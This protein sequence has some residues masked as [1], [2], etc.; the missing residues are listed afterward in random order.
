MSERRFSQV[1][2]R[3]STIV[4]L[5][6]LV[7]AA[8]SGAAK[9][10][11][12]RLG[13]EPLQRDTTN[14]LLRMDAALAPECQQRTLVKA[15]VSRPPAPTSS[16]EEAEPAGPWQE[17]WYVDR[18]GSVVAWD[19]RYTPSELGSTNLGIGLAGEDESAPV[20]R[21]EVHAKPLET[22]Q[23]P[24]S[25]FLVTNTSDSG[26]GS[27]AQAIL[28]ANASPN[29]GGPDLIDFKIPNP[30]LRTISL[31]A[32]LPPL[33][34]PVVIDGY[35]QP[36]AVPNSL[37]D[38]SNAVL[39][40][41]LD[42]SRL[43][44]PAHGL[45]LSAG[46]STV[47]GLRIQGFEG[48]AIRIEGGGSNT[49][50]GTL[51]GGSP[52]EAR[53][54]SNT[55]S[56]VVIVDSSDN[57]VGGLVPSARNV[58]EGNGGP[59]V[60][61]SGVGSIGNAILSNGIVRNA[62]EG[63]DLESDAPGG[64]AERGPGPNNLQP[65]PVLKSVSF[66]PGDPGSKAEVVVEGLLEGDSAATYRVELFATT[67]RPA[68]PTTGPAGNQRDVRSLPEGE[69]FL[70]SLEVIAGEDGK[71]GFQFHLP[72]GVHSRDT[73][74]ATATDR[75][76][77]TSEF[78]QPAGAPVFT[79]R[80]NAGT[81]NW[82]TAANWDPAVVP[83]STDDVLIAENSV[84][85]MTF[86]VTISA[87]ATANSLTLGG[88]VPTQ[89]LSVSSTLTL[90]SASTV[91]VNGVLTQTGGTITGT[92]DLTID[93]TYNWSG[94]TMSGPGTGA[95]AATTVSGPLNLNGNVA[96]ANLRILNTGGLTTWSTGGIDVSRGAIIDNTSTWDVRT[97]TTITNSLG[98][99]TFNNRG[100][101]L[102]T[103]GVTAAGTAIRVA[104]NN[105]GSTEARSGILSLGGGGISDGSYLATAGNVLVFSGGIHT[106][107]TGARVSGDGAIRIDGATLNVNT[108]VAFDV[109]GLTEMRSGTISGTGVLSI[110]GP[111]TWTGGT[112]SGAGTTSTS[113]PTK[114][115]G[116]FGKG[117]G[118]GWHLNTSGLTTWTDPGGIGTS[119][120]PFINNTGV[121]D[122]QNDASISPGSCCATFNNGGLFRKTAGAPTSSTSINIPFNNSG[123]TE[124]RA[125]VLKLLGGGS[126]TGTYSV[127]AGNVLEFTVGVSSSYTLNTGA[128]MSGDGTIRITGIS[129]N[130]NADVAFDVPG[131][132]EMRSGTITGAGTLSINGPFLWSGGTMSG[133]GGG[134]IPTTTVNGP[135][136]VNG[137]VGLDSGRVLNT[138]DL[139]TWSAGDIGFQRGA[140]INNSG[141]WEVRNDASMTL[142]VGSGTF[143]NNGGMFRKTFGVTAAG[144]VFRIAFKNTGTTESRAGLLSF[145]GGYTQTAGITMLT[146]GA[147]SSTTSINI[148]GGILAGSGT[149]TGPVIVSGMP[150]TATLA[151]GLS[152][153]TLR[154]M[155]NY[156]QQTTAQPPGAFNIEIGGTDVSQVDLAD[157]SGVAALA[158]K[159]NVSLINSFAPAS[160][161][162]FTIMK[163]QSHTGI[164]A[165][166][167]PLAGCLS[168]QVNYGS[169]S[170][171]LT[172]VNVPAEV[173]GLAFLADRVGL[174]WE[175]APIWPGT[176]YDVLR[177][178]LDK[179]PVGPGSDESCLTQPS[180][181]DTTWTDPD[182]PASGRGFWYLVRE[183]LADC[184]VG[185]YGRATNGSERMS[186]ACP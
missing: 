22:G 53:R 110:N 10:P 83:T 151:P 65:P 183:R 46:S 72:R 133:P 21:S 48:D 117:L 90:T 163:Y 129:L 92:G 99:A 36:G 62:G 78:S 55:G 153:G 141:V 103:A 17:R 111:F 6:V 98:S 4:I 119:G 118:G 176:V 145:I 40:V 85:N 30:G 79:I 58:I 49:I 9:A 131:L 13:S 68:V 77:N 181:T 172:A 136:N 28:D 57:R 74:T 43:S 166:N 155:G 108:D 123:S 61:I 126:S 16:R 96:L 14:L 125:G 94:G 138:L 143:N 128:R 124:S 159:L 5:S 91:G 12:G 33:T 64:S 154:I 175:P 173:T 174:V 44:R 112:M 135:L 178:D 29:R 152:A 80:W 160:G 140:I 73:I 24:R 120:M 82:G 180:V 47:R 114:I 76:G 34:D 171:V 134:A 150:G 146:G 39:M 23:S 84:V 144:T 69:R 148:Q 97:D 116:S 167:L 186:G 101:F 157:I 156:V 89:T 121:W 177:G 45:L 63:I 104:F 19:V 51:L 184:G 26:P 100:M 130:V 95:T 105:T 169:A 18:C 59:G 113:G 88:A 81:G 3:S 56:G 185:T 164:F 41:E 158:G 50:E 168:W 2:K 27:L 93:G 139:T 67:A 149:I 109:P 11:G 31:V 38:R 70:A 170:V 87:P 20:A 107:N 25:T 132:T 60:R 142:G 7:A 122:V 179:L 86:T 162:S 161:D 127:T 8:L 102:K 115:S 37:S 182:A 35:S 71:A 165:P 66:S 147:L 15:E 1:P 32:A 137:G 75:N 42:G 106:L 52:D 54:A